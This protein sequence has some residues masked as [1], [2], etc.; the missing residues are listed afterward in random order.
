NLLNSVSLVDSRA[1]PKSK[2]LTPQRLLSSHKLLGFTSRWI[3][4]RACAAD[5]PSW[6]YLPIV[7]GSQ[8]RQAKAEAGQH[9]RGRPKPMIATLPIRLPAPRPRRRRSPFRNRTA[10]SKATTKGS[11]SCDLHWRRGLVGTKHAG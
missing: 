7:I 10:S 5:S 3:W 1:R 6:R 2:T 9:Q 8:L 11:F 4:P